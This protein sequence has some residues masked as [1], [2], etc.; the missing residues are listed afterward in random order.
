MS[1]SR[2]RQRSMLLQ[3]PKDVAL[4]IALEVASNSACLH[5]ICALSL[6]C[7][8]LWLQL[9]DTEHPL[10]VWRLHTLLGAGRFNGSRPPS[11]ELGPNGFDLGDGLG[12]ACILT[13]G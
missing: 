5:D 3:L 10:W 12:P 8:E 9:Q 13:S 1:R 6:A 2:R 11:F 4:R 7:P